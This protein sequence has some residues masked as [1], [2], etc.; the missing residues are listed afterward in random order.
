MCVD[1]MRKVARKNEQGRRRKCGGGNRGQ[2]VKVRGEGNDW[3]DRG[4][5]KGREGKG[6]SSIR[7]RNPMRLLGRRERTGWEGGERR[8][9]VI[10]RGPREKGQRGIDRGVE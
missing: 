1:V 6:Q 4:G 8:M 3:T 10:T 5:A 7:G 9:G 2:G